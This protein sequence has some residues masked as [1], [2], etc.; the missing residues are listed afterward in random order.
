MANYPKNSLLVIAT[1][2]LA[3]IAT[4]CKKEKTSW[5]ADF[6]IPIAQTTLS[7]NNIIADS[8][9]A[10]DANNHV[11]IS[12]NTDIFNY[13]IDSIIKIPDTVTSFKYHAYSTSTLS[14]GQPIALTSEVKSFN[15]EPARITQ[16]D[17][18]QGFLVYTCLNPLTTPLIIT[19]TI[20]A[21]KKNGVAFLIKETIPA[22]DGVTPKSYTS[23]IDL[24]DYSIDMRG[25]NLDNSNRFQTSMYIT[26]DPNGSPTTMT[27]GQEF[28]FHT[29]FENLQLN[30]IKGYLG[31]EIQTTGPDTT[32]FDFF[33]RISCSSLSLNN[34][35]VTLKISNG[36]GADIRFIPISL[37]SKNG[38]TGQ[39][40]PLSGDIIGKSYNITRA[41]E[42]HQAT[43]PVKPTI[44]TL[45]FSN[46]NIKS[47]IENLPNQFIFGSSI[48]INPLGNISN[49]NDFIYSNN[50]LSAN[51]NI[52][53]PLSFKANSMILSDT[54]VYKTS[55][56][57]K[58]NSGTI[59][60]L[61]SNSFPVNAKIRLFILDQNN[62]PTN[63]IT[64][65][66]Q[67]IT[68]GS[69]DSNNAPIASNSILKL[70]LEGE[71]LKRFF[72]SNKLL[73]TSEINTAG[74]NYV[75]ISTKSS[76]QVKIVG[77][78]NTNI[79]Y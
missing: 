23:R 44:S 2:L 77:N 27:N 17:I 28:T 57:E 34:I 33:Q 72:T 45:D 47:L 50:G 63:E 65:A 35:D 24:S 78:F 66:N 36:I 29:N 26:T 15:F 48:Q 42:T 56:N 68:A 79:E 49:G 70:N 38:S 3:L 55:S 1:L 10:T 18:K 16:V 52:K 51:L 43:N 12:Y 41:S 40:T 22:S 54:L 37:S 53:I 32:A 74:T 31:N 20:P 75:N 39:V 62:Q 11:S 5:D 8:L 30:Y 76:I 64:P 61:I 21:A 4:S 67:W 71:T 13:N 59:S 58:I 9:I 14:P 19:Y 60:L 7:L 73:L 69:E 46:T 6:T 25:P